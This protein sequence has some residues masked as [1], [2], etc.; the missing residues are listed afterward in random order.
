MTIH[1]VSESTVRRALH[2]EGYHGRVGV[3]KPFV[4]EVNRIKRL[5][6]SQERLAW[7]S[8]W[9]FIIWS[10]ESRF[11]LSGGN[12]RKWVWRRTEQRMDVDCL[13]PTF[14]SGEKSVMVWGCFTRF[15]VG[16][17]VRL[18]GRLAA[19]DYVK[20]LET[21][22]V[23]FLESLDDKERFTF[24]EDNAPIHTAKKTARWQRENGIP[25]LPWTAQSPDLNP[26]EHLWDELERRLRARKV[27]PKNEDELYE[28]LLEEWK[29]IP[30]SVL[31]KLVD[32][33]P[34]RVEEVC[35]AKG[36][37]TRY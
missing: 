22:L 26:I 15:G 19:V 30:I 5:K 1:D 36:N 7:D 34:K 25:C 23:P 9:N 27:P 35:N 37:P 11:E 8:E 28:F 2:R 20:V 14:K 24:Q 6:W 29:K 21:H 12:R 13:I 17:L 3:R 32:S 33:M 10:D 16:P 4:S 31:E 18:Q